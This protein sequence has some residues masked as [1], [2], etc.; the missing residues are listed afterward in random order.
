M[1]WVFPT[2]P[3]SPDPL[4]RAVRAA[5]RI[6]ETEAVARILDAAES[7]PAMTARIEATARN[8]VLEAR[9]RRHGKGGIDALL[10]EFALSSREGIA[11]MCLAE[12]LLRVP[13]AETID[14]LI[15]DKLGPADWA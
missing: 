11:L 1:E 13:D 5:Y 2:P 9:K 8:L 4:R 15:R 10:N 6:D 7:P 12:A 14:R 3:A